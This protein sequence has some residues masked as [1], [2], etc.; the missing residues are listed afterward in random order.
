MHV[1]VD[2]VS[3]WPAV[4]VQYMSKMYTTNAM[5]VCTG[6]SKRAHHHNLPPGGPPSTRLGMMHRNSVDML[7]THTGLDHMSG[8][9]VSELSEEWDVPERSTA[10]G[11]SLRPAKG[12]LSVCVPLR[13]RRIMRCIG[14]VLICS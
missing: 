9:V 4:F 2:K 8:S 10:S 6:M 12:I 7:G 5:V 13:E 1:N 11:D 14:D 3:G